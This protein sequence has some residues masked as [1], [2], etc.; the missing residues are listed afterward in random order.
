MLLRVLIGRHSIRNVATLFQH[1]SS[2]SLLSTSGTNVTSKEL[3]SNV[4]IVISGPTG[5][6]KNDIVVK[7]YAECK[8]VIVSADAVQRYRGVQIGANKST[9]PQEHTAKT[10]PHLLV[11]MVD[12]FKASIHISARQVITYSKALPPVFRRL[13]SWPMHCS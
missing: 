9:L 3:P 6:G 10:T 4:I 7:I 5:V 1:K 11:D 2:S 8:G 13:E 12:V